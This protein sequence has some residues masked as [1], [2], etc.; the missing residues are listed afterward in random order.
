MIF[1][2]PTGDDG[3]HPVSPLLLP[4]IN[5]PP[6]RSEIVHRTRYSVIAYRK[7]VKRTQFSKSVMTP[8]N[9]DHFY[10][11]V[12]EMLDDGSASSV[13]KTAET[14]KFVS[15]SPKLRKSNKRSS[16]AKAFKHL[17]DGSSY[18]KQEIEQSEERVRRIRAGKALNY[19][20]PESQKQFVAPNKNHYNRQRLGTPDSNNNGLKFCTRKRQVSLMNSSPHRPFI[21]LPSL[22]DILLNNEQNKERLFQ[23][24]NNLN[25]KI[26]KLEKSFSKRKPG[27]AR[28]ITNDPEKKLIKIVKSHLKSENYDKIIQDDPLTHFYDRLKEFEDGK[29]RLKTDLKD[30]LATQKYDRPEA[31]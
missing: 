11:K 22:K 14:A 13:D 30:L 6:S 25:Q 2:D 26:E 18:L 4:S 28:I 16:K 19:I 21:L 12:K 7:P 10:H 8:L 17:D 23:S 29:E 5:P 1:S 15:E 31:I 9:V 27:D 24:G 20:I 3:I